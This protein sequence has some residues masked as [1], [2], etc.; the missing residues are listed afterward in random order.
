MREVQTN[1]HIPAGETVWNGGDF[2]ATAP[3]EPGTYSLYEL[4]YDSTNAH[5]GWRWEREQDGRMEVN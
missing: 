2:Y 4:I 5:A 1:E 3:K